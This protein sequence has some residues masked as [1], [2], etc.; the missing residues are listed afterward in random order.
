MTK[1]YGLFVEDYRPSKLDEC[2][3]PDRI[4]EQVRGYAKSGD[5]PSMIFEGPAGTGKTTLAKA[6]C[7][8]IGA[9]FIVINGSTDRNIDTLR[10]RVAGFASTT[11]IV[12]D[13]KVPKVVIYDEA[14]GLNPQS[15]Q[16]AL[17]GMMEEFSATCRFIFTCN[18]SNKLIE[19]IHSR[20]AV[21]SFYFNESEKKGLI[22]KFGARVFSI[23]NENNISYDKRV[24]AEFIK[25]HFPDMRKCL[26]ELQAFSVNGSVDDSI[27]DVARAQDFVQDVV[28]AVKRKSFRD[29]RKLVEENQDLLD[30]VF[31]DLVYRGL[32]DVVQP[33]S[34]PD[35]VLTIADYIHKHSTSPL[36]VVT[37]TACLTTVMI[38]CDMK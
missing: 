1:R 19:P 26:N 24:V 7:N 28:D 8:E 38:E 10:N 14:D 22:K 3:L 30:S 5:F 16:P 25:R 21:F 37:A 11:S 33:N 34:I 12:G 18:Y 27:L 20:C 4:L 23:L 29:M 17:R 13:S 6:F 2:V 31:Y 15:S 32:S 35:L 36:P 9:Q